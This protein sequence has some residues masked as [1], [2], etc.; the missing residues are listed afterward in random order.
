MFLVRLTWSDSRFWIGGR[1]FCP[2]VGIRNVWLRY[3]KPKHQSAKPKSYVR[4]TTLWNDFFLRWNRDDTLAA[5]KIIRGGGEEGKIEEGGG[6]FSNNVITII[7][8]P[9]IQTIIDIKSDE[10]DDNNNRRTRLVVLDFASNNCPPCDMIKPYYDELSL[11]DKF[12]NN[13]I[14][15]KVNISDYPEVATHYNIDTWP[16]FVLFRDGE[17][18]DKV[19][20]GMASREGLYDLILKH[21]STWEL[22]TTG[23]RVY[24]IH[25]IFSLKID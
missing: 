18:V 8:L 14:F 10:Q 21:S 24:A 1:N 6:A 11:L 7:S 20:G 13:V 4:M 12:Q 22:K 9:Q 5:I 19:V 23:K 3:D 16:T 2:S 25:A 15:C 17:I